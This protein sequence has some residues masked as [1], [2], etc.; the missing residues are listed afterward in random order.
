MEKAASK[1]GVVPYSDAGSPIL[2]RNC[3]SRQYQTVFVACIRDSGVRS[4][5]TLVKM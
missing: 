3:K 1:K 2:A 4:E 5:I